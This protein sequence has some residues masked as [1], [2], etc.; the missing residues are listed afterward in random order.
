MICG[1]NGTPTHVSN[2][3]MSDWTY[4]WRQKR[5]KWRDGARAH[6][7]MLCIDTILHKQA[8]SWML[9]LNK[10]HLEWRRYC[11]RAHCDPQNSW[12][13]SEMSLGHYV[14]FCTERLTSQNICVC[15]TWAFGVVT[16]VN[17]YGNRSTEQTHLPK[18][19]EQR[20][21]IMR[22]HGSCCYN[23][24]Q[25]T[26][27]SLLWLNEDGM[28]IRRMHLMIIPPYRTARSLLVMIHLVYVCVYV[29][30]YVSVVCTCVHT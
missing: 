6:A 20:M 17:D 23:L 29:C 27:P 25:R 21:S 13:Y 5:V 4:F 22:M 9:M 14:L 19:R 10:R 11:F 30:M 2:A 1:G 18:V 7:G 24:G 12:L 15:V 8:P 26:C 16:D 3:F 28:S